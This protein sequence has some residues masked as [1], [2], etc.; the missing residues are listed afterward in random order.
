MAAGLGFAILL[1][2]NF[3]LSPKIL[4]EMQTHLNYASKCAN[5]GWF[6]ALDASLEVIAPTKLKVYIPHHPNPRRAE[7]VVSA[8][9]IWEQSLEQHVKFERV[10]SQNGADV[11]FRFVEEI[12]G[13]DGDAGGFAEWKR[14]VTRVQGDYIG[15]TTAL[16]RLADSASGRKFNSDALLQSALHEIGHVL[17]LDDSKGS[18]DVMGPLDLSR[19]ITRPQPAEINALKSLRALG[20]NIN[21]VA[22]RR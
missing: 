22:Q 5:S 11:T 15:K 9:S 16:V 10:Q 20:H 18:N 4:P 17:G 8:L 3:G 13:R 2:G 12:K 6:S 1:V 7:A 14:T 21:L 19:P